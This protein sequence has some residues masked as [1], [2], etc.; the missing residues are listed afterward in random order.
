MAGSITVDTTVD[1][2]VDDVLD[3]L[4]DDDLREELAK[5]GKPAAAEVDNE[6]RM[7]TVRKLLSKKET[8]T[9]EEWDELKYVLG[10]VLYPHLRP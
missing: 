9:T 2:W 7:R 3:E 1:V 8:P 6:W 5:R 4:S 10:A